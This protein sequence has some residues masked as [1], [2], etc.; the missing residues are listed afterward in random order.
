MGR[1]NVFHRFAMP[2]PP[3]S[4]RKRKQQVGGLP[5]LLPFL[6]PAAV[7]AAKAAA[8]GAVAAGVGYGVK[9]GL[10]KVGGRRRR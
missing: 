1:K 7:A 5:F 10:Q 8:G 3:R 9:K 6:I 4:R 2:R